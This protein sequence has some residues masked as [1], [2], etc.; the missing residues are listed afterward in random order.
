MQK[1]GDHIIVLLMSWT[2][3]VPKEQPKF[4]NAVTRGVTS[5]NYNA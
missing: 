3:N 4:V 1:S 2:L 5:D